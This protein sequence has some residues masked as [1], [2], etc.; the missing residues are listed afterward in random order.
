MPR[1]YARAYLA[2][3]VDHIDSLCGKLA[4]D[5]ASLDDEELR[6]A[7]MLVVSLQYAFRPGQIARIEL[8]DVRLFPTGAVHVAVSIIKQK[9]NSKRIRITRKIKREWGPLCNELIRRREAGL[10]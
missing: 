9:D 2:L 7:C 1:L 6:D 10:L 5:P 3:I 8:A 4:V